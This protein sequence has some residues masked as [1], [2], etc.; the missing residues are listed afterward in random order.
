[1]SAA[2]QRARVWSPVSVV[3]VLDGDEGNEQGEFWRVQ[4]G[5][6]H[7]EAEAIEVAS[8][9]RTAIQAAT[10]AAR[11]R[12][13]ELEDALLDAL[14]AVT[15][16]ANE[17]KQLQEQKWQAHK[18][19]NARVAAMRERCAAQVDARADKAY[20]QRDK[21]R[22]GSL[23]YFGYDLAGDLFRREA[24]E[25]RALDEKEGE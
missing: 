11:E 24:V 23:R 7:T 2:D 12:V 8:T 20:A 22:K 18:Q 3:R 17:I 10:A 5:D 9:I 15:K 25:I 21:Q 4:L 19:F 6:Y 13:E 14:L 16:E 1:M